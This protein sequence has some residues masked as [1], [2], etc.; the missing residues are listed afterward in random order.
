MKRANQRVRE[1]FRMIHKKKLQGTKR[2]ES[3]WKYRLELNFE[4]G[5]ERS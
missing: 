2:V 4:I 3:T 1:K 5:K